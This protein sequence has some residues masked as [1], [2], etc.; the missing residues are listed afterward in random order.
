MTGSEEGSLLLLDEKSGELYMRAS[1][2]FNDD[3][4]NTFRLP[5]QD[6][7]A[8]SVLRSGKPVILDEKTPQKIKPPIWLTA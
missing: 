7:L 8:G 4:V 2:N 6:S 5:I 3:F 1:R